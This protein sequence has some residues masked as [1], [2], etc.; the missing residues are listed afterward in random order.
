MSSDVLHPRSAPNH[1][2]SKRKIERFH[3]TVKSEHLR[4]TPKIT[5]A[6]MKAELGRWIG[7]YNKERLRSS[8]GY[9]SLFDVIF[10]RRSEITKIRDE[11]YCLANLNALSKMEAY[12][13]ACAYNLRR[14]VNLYNSNLELGCI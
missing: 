13:K 1:P 12:L 3:G 11:N 8:L 2:Q 9:V 10:G 14:A 6:Q 5:L 4:K 7:Y